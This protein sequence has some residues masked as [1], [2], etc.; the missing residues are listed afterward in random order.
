[1]L[2]SA[3][4]FYKKLRND[5]ESIGFEVNPYDP[6]I[7]NKVIDGKQMIIMWHVDDIKISHEDGWEITKMIKWLGKIYRD[8]KVKR[9]RK[10]HYLGM[11]LDFQNK[12]VVEVSM[13]SYAEEIIK[14]FPEEIGN[15][16]AST[17]AAEH[18]FQV[19]KEK[20]KH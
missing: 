3:L 12:G 15:S 9:G 1:M 7:A 11:D 18:L 6:C 4:L 8:I 5:L 14:S 16:Y 2:K 19:R 20:K 13:I 10:Q 17:P